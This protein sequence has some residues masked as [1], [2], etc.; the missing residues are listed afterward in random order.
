MGGPAA[1][2]CAHR[3]RPSSSARWRWRASRGFAGFFSKDLILEAVCEQAASGVRSALLL[4]AAFLTAFYMGRVMFM[5]FFGE[6]SRARPRHAHECGPA[7]A[8]A[9]GRPR[10]CPRWSRASSARRCSGLY[11]TEYQR[12]STS[13]AACIAATALGLA[14]LGVAWLVFG[15]ARRA[16]RRSACAPLRPTR[17]SGRGRTLLRARSTAGCC[18][19]SRAFVGWIDRYVVDGL[20]NFVGWAHDRGR[21]SA[22]ASCRPARCATTRCAVVA[23][24]RGRWRLVGGAAMSHLLL[25]PSS[26]RPR[27]SRRRAPAAVPDS[28]RLAVR[29]VSLHR[30]GRLAGRRGRRW[31]A[32]YDLQ[33]RAACS[34]GEVYPLVPAP[35]HRP[36]AGGRRLGRVAAAAHRHHHLHRR[37]GR[38]G[39]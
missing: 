35:R 32:L 1:R 36:Q 23:G 33:R 30:R 5:A 16:R 9:P 4:G 22:R 20:M 31:P 28:Q 14:G 6:P 17:A 38:A 3:R 29:L 39:R 2:R 19:A 11:G 10:R 34:C 27:S 24:R 37:A 18:S 21:R 13:S 7:M 26:R 15:A 12:T 25:P 8:A